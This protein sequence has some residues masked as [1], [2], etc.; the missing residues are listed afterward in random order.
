MEIEKKKERV[1]SV[2]TRM[3]GRDGLT[4]VREG[5]AP[6][7]RHWNGQTPVSQDTLPFKAVEFLS[8]GVPRYPPIQ[9]ETLR[10]TL[11]NGF[12]SFSCCCR[13]YS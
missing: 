3:R 9:A 11:N 10:I 12:I 7:A 6:K 5:L 4:D 13:C 8:F 2:G 1:S